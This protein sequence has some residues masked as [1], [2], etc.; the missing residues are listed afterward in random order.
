MTDTQSV[1][2]RVRRVVAHAAQAVDQSRD[3]LDDLNVYPVPDGDTGTNLSLTMGTVRSAIEDDTGSTAEELARTIS[4]AAL[5]GA[6][7]NSGIILSQIVKGLA[8]S[9]GAAARLDAASVADAL[10]SASDAAYAAVAKPVEGTM[11]TVVRELAEAAEEARELPLD[12]ALDRTLAA[13]EASLARTPELLRILADAGVVDAGGAGVIELL[14]GRSPGSAAPPCTSPRM[15]PRSRGGRRT[16]MRRNRRSGTART[17]SSSPPPSTRTTSPG[18]SI[19]SATAS[20]SS[21][22]GRRSRSTCTRTI[23]AGRSRSPPPSGASPASTSPTCASR[24]RSGRRGSPSATCPSCPSRWSTVPATSSRSSRG[25]ATRRPRGSRAVR[26]IV[27][28]G[29]SAN[30]SID[31]LLQAIEA[32][33]ADGVIVLPNNPNVQGAAERAAASASVPCRVVASPSMAVGLS[34]LVG[35]RPEASLEE[36]AAGMSDALAGIAYGEVTRAVRDARVD[37]LDVRSG[38]HVG[39][40]G[41]RLVV[42]GDRLEHAIAIVLQHLVEGDPSV[43]TILLGAGFSDRAALD[44]AL[45]ELAGRELEVDVVDGG[46]PHYELLLAA[47]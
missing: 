45:G 8:G 30:P 16:C 23:P 14:R 11:L 40:V 46:Q 4:R 31:E 37:G 28:G 35:Y 32:C 36:N 5:M 21:A 18:T 44:G 42:A 19:R 41:G 39:L 29:Q 26:G 1:L 3:R 15:R 22:T 17:S 27:A 47:E 13:G 25:R 10:R 9:L 24:S 12:A 7:G 6:R 33:A 34:L 2:A 43:L 38:Q 20:S